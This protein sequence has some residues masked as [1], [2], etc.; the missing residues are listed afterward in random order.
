MIKEA[1][2]VI[3]KVR[4]KVPLV[5]AITNY[6]T[7]NDCANI[8]LAFGASPAMVEA[9]DEAYDFAAISSAIYINLGTLTKEQEEAAVL[10]SISAKV[11]KVPV[12][13]DPVACSAIPRKNLV[14]K[15][16]LELGRI[17]VIKGNGGEIKFLA[18]QASKTRGVDSVDDGEGLEKACVDLAQKYNCVVAATGKE[19]IITDGERVAIIQNGVEMLT[20]ITGAGCML[21]ALCSAAVGAEKDS[22][23]AVVNAV[24]S[25]NLAGEAAFKEVQLPGSFRTKLIDNV[26]LLSEERYAK[27]GKVIWK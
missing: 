17:D 25:I 3:T 24:L 13:L 10:A 27:E 6:V 12:V 19:D 4:N 14:I 9:Y 22:F 20:K 1:A 7:V 11:N 23:I 26:Y 18:G 15:R 16:M 2:S 5:Q 21:G 8:L